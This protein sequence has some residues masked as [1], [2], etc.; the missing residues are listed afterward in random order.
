MN[1]CPQGFFCFQKS[2]FII[3]CVLI[4]IC[5]YIFI[6]INQNDSNNVLVLNNEK[7]NNKENDIRYK[8]INDPLYPPEK[9]YPINIKTRGDSYDYQQVGFAFNNDNK[10]PIYGR[11]TYPGSNKYNYYTKSDGYQSVKLPVI[12][13]DRD[14]TDDNGCEQLQNDDKI[15]VTSYGEN[16]F[17]FNSYKFDKPKYIPYI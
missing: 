15:K 11:Q 4:I 13:N 17:N 1:S 5:L 12:I 7:L 9:T 6:R 2:I 10:L 16:E 14:C 3:C 8:R